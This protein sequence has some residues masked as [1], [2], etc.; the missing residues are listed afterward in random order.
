[1]IQLDEKDW[2]MLKVLYAEKSITKAAPS[3]YLSQPALIYRMDQLEKEMD[4]QLFIRSSKGIHFTSAGERLVVFAEKM[5]RE[6]ADIKNRIVSQEGAVSG[7]LRLG[8]SSIFAHSQLP[9]LLKE[10]NQKYPAIEISLYTGLSHDVLKQM[11]KEEIAVAIIRGNHPWK[12]ADLLLQ[13]EPLC[14]VSAKAL[15]LKDL[16]TIPGIQ[17]LTDPTMQYQIDRW[18]QENFSIPPKILMHVDSAYTCRQLVMAGLGW[19][20]MPAL[21]LP[22]NIEN[23][24]IQEIKN[25]NDQLYDR[26]TRLI[27]R[28]AAR[29]IDAVDVF[30]NFIENAF[31]AKPNA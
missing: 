25:K 16:P 29:E 3:L 27:Y 26:P 7:T 23:L 21:R 2:Q 10:F 15:S 9:L 13:N 17:Y 14:I 31:K 1:M 18:W 30:I 19:A 24:F 5:I 4:T 28:N 22:E 11:H 12:E 6:Y 20:I 8:S